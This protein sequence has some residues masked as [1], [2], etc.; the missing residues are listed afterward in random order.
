MAKLQV[1][2]PCAGTVKPLSKVNDPVFAQKMIGDGV[3][4]TP[5]EEEIYATATGKVNAAFPTGHAYGIKMTGGPDLL[6]HI[7][8]DTVGM[9]G[10]GFKAHAKKG[11]SVKAGTTKLATIDLAKIKKG[12]K[13][14]DIIVVATN[15][16]M[17]D[18]KIT[19][20]AKGKVEKGDLI[21]EIE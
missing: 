1:F 14:T 19:N 9:K 13:S 20:R 4:V 15:E 3:A 21:F 2:A 17:G 5:K 11:K 7:G 12:A 16:T 10:D 6:V 8:V 18:Y